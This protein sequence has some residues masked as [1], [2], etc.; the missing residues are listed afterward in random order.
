MM[1]QSPFH[2]AQLALFFL[3]SPHTIQLGI[4]LRNLRILSQGLCC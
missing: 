1:N 4:T 3:K 2:Q